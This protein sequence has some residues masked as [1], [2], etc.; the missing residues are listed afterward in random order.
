[1]ITF[2]NLVFVNFFCFGVHQQTLR[3]EFRGLMDQKFEMPIVPRRGRLILTCIENGD[4]G[5][6][7]LQVPLYRNKHIVS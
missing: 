5:K 4:L 3:E 2:F 1:M 7:N 6:R